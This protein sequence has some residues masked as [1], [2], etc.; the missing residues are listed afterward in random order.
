M[1]KYSTKDFKNDMQK[2]YKGS[3]CKKCKTSHMP[4]KH[5]AAQTSEVKKKVLTAK[6][7]KALPATTFALPGRKYPIPDAAHG[8]NA[9]ARVSQFGSPAQKAKVR[10]AVHR[11]FPGIGKK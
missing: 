2:A 3:M 6:T 10:A 8:R 5:K 11:K 7:R 4:G 1:A 9:L